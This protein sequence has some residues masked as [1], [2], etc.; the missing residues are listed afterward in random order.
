MLRQ[1]KEGKDGS[2]CGVNTQ[3]GRNNRPGSTN[4]QGSLVPVGLVFLRFWTVL[5]SLYKE[6]ILAF[7]I[8]LLATGL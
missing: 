7:V 1:G 4:T 5:S 2:S 8:G 6:A 3:A